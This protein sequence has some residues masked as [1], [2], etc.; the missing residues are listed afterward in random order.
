MK[1]LLLT[2]LLPVT[3]LPIATIVSCNQTEK[4]HKPLPIKG[5]NQPDPNLEDHKKAFIMTKLYF[6]GMAS[7]Y[8]TRKP[9]DFQIN[10]II[11]YDD[12]I[13]KP[14]AFKM[15]LSKLDPRQ[16]YGFRTYWKKDSV[17]LDDENGTISGKIVLTR[18]QERYEE[19][20]SIDGFLTS[21]AEKAEKANKNINPDWAVEN[22]DRMALSTK[23]IKVSDPYL[24]DFYDKYAKNQDLLLED[25]KSQILSSQYLDQTNIEFKDFSQ[26]ERFG[27][28]VPE[29]GAWYRLVDVKNPELKSGWYRIT[30]FGFDVVQNG[31]R[32]PELFDKY[33][34][35][36]QT[37]SNP[38]LITESKHYLEVDPL[39]IKDVV[40]FLKYVD[41]DLLEKQTIVAKPVEII[42]ADDKKGYLEVA[43]NVNYKYG[44]E[45]F[46]GKENVRIKIFGFNPK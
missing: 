11:T 21:K 43:F 29:I 42:S 27:M 35:D 1:K 3:I 40:T 9:S 34:Q 38:L 31:F 30:W 23:S 26:V 33:V 5:I 25:F 39:T 6:Q 18:G 28:A 41:K 12:I 45:D 22:F 46:P 19:D 32:D 4:V 15:T 8:A 37:I 16:N 7:I 14:P 13:I 36:W 24:D 2:T 20:M 17:K 44:P 10:N